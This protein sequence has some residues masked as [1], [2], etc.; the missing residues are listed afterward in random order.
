MVVC[1]GVFANGVPKPDKLWAMARRPLFLV[2]LI[3]AAV[4]SVGL[5]FRTAD[6][7]PATA[8][9][10]SGTVKLISY[11]V[12]GLLEGV[13]QSHPRAN[14]P[15]IGAHLNLFDLA[16]VQEDFCYHPRIAGQANHAHASA[17]EHTPGCTRFFGDDTDMG[18]GLNRFSQTPF[19]AHER[20]DWDACNGRLDC[21]SDCLGDK[22][23][24]VATHT[25]AEGVTVDVYNL[26]MD[27]G[28]CPEDV[29]AR[30]AQAEQLISEV[31]RRSAQRAVIVGGDTNLT[32]ST[33]DAEVLNRL[34]TGLRLTDSCTATG[35]DHG[36]RIDR[37]L[38]RSGATL[39]L[40]ADQWSEPSAFVDDT[41]APLSD[42]PP[43]A[44]RLQ[45]ERVRDDAIT[46][47]TEN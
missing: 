20:F 1:A 31:T 18:D 47:H 16:L 14:S 35:C 11:N 33:A 36:G 12:A 17:P 45:W 32:D 44:V 4:G 38:F 40:T 34:L 2:L 15:L 29:V 42:H 7:A 19:A 10:T 30:A 3:V 5:A 22:G 43:L 9:V 26:H 46:V 21:E 27:A 37:V 23:F 39:R 24:S 25:L 13:S 6:D 41:G 28:Q 8:G